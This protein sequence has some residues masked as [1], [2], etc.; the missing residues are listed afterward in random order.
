MTVNVQFI[1]PT[2][3]RVHFLKLCLDALL[4]Q[5]IIPTK[6]LVGVRPDDVESIQVV[7]AYVRMGTVKRIDAKGVGVIG[8]MTSCLQEADG[9][10]IGLVDDDVELPLD[11]VEKMLAHMHTYSDVVGCAGRDML[12]DA[13]EMRAQEP[14]TMDVGR[15]HWYGRITGN[16]HRG[17]GIARKVQVLRGSNILFRGEFLRKAS[18]EQNLRGQGAQVNWELALAFQVA[19]NRKAM[20]Y[21][22]ATEVLHYTAPRYDSDLVHRGVFTQKAIADMSYNECLV[23]L[24]HAPTLLKFKVVLWQFL[25]GTKPSPGIVN[26]ALLILSRTKE[27][28]YCILGAFEGRVAAL[29]KSL[30]SKS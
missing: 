24:N 9:E 19:Q 1:V 16:H 28:R 22:P 6:I 11:W 8:S 14:L 7:D 12:Q 21:D 15:I 2:L 30:L 29:K 5:T 18:F 20:L 25:V 27:A 4:G 10:F 23:T 13:P 17:G 3:K 26:A